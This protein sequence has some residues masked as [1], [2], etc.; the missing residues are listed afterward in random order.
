MTYVYALHTCSVLW[1]NRKIHV[2]AGIPWRSDD[3]FVRDQPNLFSRKPPIT[4]ATVEQ[5]VEQAT[6]APG[7]K[8]RTARG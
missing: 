7:E 8:R 2:T 3:P 1:Q 5:P 6:Q 4:G